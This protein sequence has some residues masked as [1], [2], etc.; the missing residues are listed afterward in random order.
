MADKTVQLLTASTIIA[1]SD[2]LV[3][4]DDPTGSGPSK[5]ITFEN[6]QKNITN[7]GKTVDSIIELIGTIPNLR[8]SFLTM[9]KLG[10]FV[11]LDTGFNN[12]LTGTGQNYLNKFGNNNLTGATTDSIAGFCSWWWMWHQAD[13]IANRWKW[14]CRIF[15]STNTDKMEYWVGF[16]ES[17]AN[18]PVGTDNHYGFKWVST[19]DGASGDLYA[20]NGNGATQT[21]TLIAAGINGWDPFYLIASY[22]EN[23]IKYYYSADNVT[24]N[25]VATHTTNIPTGLNLAFCHWLKN[26]EAV[27]KQVEMAAFRFFEGD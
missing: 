4:N 18:F 5:K 6:L 25:L 27:N 20:T 24:W 19:V 8:D 16:F 1:K 7:L 15:A 2:L 21:T 9:S 3:M 17:N 12:V 22:E 11:E 13:Q 10:M 23:S 14:A 26:T